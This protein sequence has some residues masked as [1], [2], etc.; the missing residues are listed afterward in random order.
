MSVEK[1]ADYSA[2]HVLILWC[3]YLWISIINYCGIKD[4]GILAFWAAM[5]LFIVCTGLDKS[6]GLKILLYE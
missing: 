6:I 2:L 1:S 3:S 5:V 4:H